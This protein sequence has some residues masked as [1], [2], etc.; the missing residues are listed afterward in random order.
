MGRQNNSQ[1]RNWMLTIFHGNKSTP[2][3]TPEHGGS[4]IASKISRE[5][6]LECRIDRIMSFSPG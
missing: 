6:D 1:K 4:H 3:N 2:D 5:N